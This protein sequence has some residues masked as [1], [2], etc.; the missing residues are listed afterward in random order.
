MCSSD[1]ETGVVT[2]FFADLHNE[3]MP[4]RICHEIARLAEEGLINA[5][6]HSRASALT[7]RVGSIGGNWVVV[8]VDDGVGFDFRGTWS[9]EQLVTARLGPRVIKERVLSLDGN[10][11]IESTPTGA[12]IEISIPQ[13]GKLL[14][15]FRTTSLRKSRE[16]EPYSSSNS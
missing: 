1:L 13:S 5:Q 11:I 3:P 6:K 7:I 2:R 14:D 8:I 4:P 10:L 9:L 15:P 12:R 16:D